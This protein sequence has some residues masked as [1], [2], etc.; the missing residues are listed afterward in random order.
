ML[1][2]F[3][4]YRDAPS[5]ENHTISHKQQAPSLL[6]G[7]DIAC[8]GEGQALLHVLGKFCELVLGAAA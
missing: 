1:L 6:S 7:Q 2:D 3:F 8:P 5:P 4:R